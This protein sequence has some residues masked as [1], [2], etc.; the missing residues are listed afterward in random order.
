MQNV[1]NG[2]NGKNGIKCKHG[3]NENPCQN[4]KNG[5]TANM[6]NTA[7]LFPTFDHVFFLLDKSLVLPCV[8]QSE[9]QESSFG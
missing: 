9:I 3:K 1:K 6:V 5:K 7:V 8:E 2:E 4:A